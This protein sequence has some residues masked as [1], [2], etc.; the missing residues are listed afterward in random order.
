MRFPVIRQLESIDCGPSCVRMVSK[1]Y[2]KEV[3]LSFLKEKCSFSRLGISVA[4][5][6]KCCEFV[7]LQSIVV[8][9][10]VVQLINAPLPVILHWNQ[11]HFVVLHEI[12][13]IRKKIYFYIVDP[14]FGRIKLDESEFARQW[15][16]QRDAGV[17]MLVSPNE[18][19]SKSSILKNK[20]ENLVIKKIGDKY[21]DNK[22]QV[23][24]SLLLLGIAAAFNWVMPILFQK[25]I[26]DGVIPKNIH[27]VWQLMLMQFVFYVSY[28]LSNNVSSLLL[29]KANFKISLEYLAELLLKMVK[30]PIKYFDTRLNTDFIQRLDDQT[31]LQNFL[32]FKVTDLFFSFVNVVIFSMLL[33]YYNWHILLV[34]L[35][36]SLLST[37]WTIYILRRRKYL[38]YSFFTAQAEN[39]NIIYE[40]IM[41]MVEIKINN[42]QRTRIN[43]WRES[44]NKINAISL[45]TLYLNYYQTIGALSVNKIR[46]II[47]TTI[48][49]FLVIKADMTLGIMM[50][51][52]YILGQ[53]AAPLS[54]IQNLIKDS[55]DAKI[56][57][58]RLDEV[59]S[60]E[61]ENSELNK[62]CPVFQYSIRLE[63]VSFKYE[64]S[65]NPLVLKGLNFDFLSNK[66]TAIVGNSGSGKTTLLKLLLGFYYAQQGRV[67]IDNMEINKINLDLWR[68]KCGAVMQD[69]CIFS[70]TVAENIALGDE[71]INYERVKQCAEIACI[72][73]YVESLPGKYKMRI[74]KSG[75]DM[76]GGQKQRILIAR[77]VYKN[78]QLIIFDEATSHLDTINEK[79]IMN[80][81]KSFF[82]GKTVIIVAHRLSTVA[83]A[84]RIMFLEKG[85][86]V[87][88][89]DHK[90]LVSLKGKYYQLIRNQL[91]LNL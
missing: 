71:N 42:A 19:F 54:Q 51:V 73:E 88:E 10:T 3:P 26:D 48:C 67:L 12:K 58:D 59:Q 41:G 46:D 27:I 83:D 8:K 15:L 7:D 44:Q 74:G 39:K 23:I 55:L 50:S 86:I 32:T 13:R 69:G 2:G 14:G 17:A 1:Y 76:S 64:G 37:L 24:T 29:M 34:F 30:L 82:K 21:K 43:I 11:N 85:K 18:K 70:G 78:P 72:D 79:N 16:N 45:K 81:L 22:K 6:V 40:L 31:R 56:S 38:D 91:E 49:A 68:E 62:E 84:D 52:S 60:K 28:M 63:N 47:I 4:D 57:L 61:D 77:A 25:T 87:E 90:T 5:V 35:F 20:K 75:I 36:F 9:G 80:N 89:G 66:I 53:L 65:F 33:A